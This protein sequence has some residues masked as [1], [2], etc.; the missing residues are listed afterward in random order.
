[1]ALP[2]SAYLQ[3]KESAPEVATIEV[4]SA[5]TQSSVSETA[6]TKVQ[7]R[8][9][10]IG[11]DARARVLKVERTATDL[12]PDAMIRLRYVHRPLVQQSMQDGKW[13]DVRMAG[14]SPIPLLEKGDRVTA[15][16][17][18]LS[19]DEFE[20]AAEAESFAVLAAP[21]TKTD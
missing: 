13:S 10:E 11:V 1:M 5:E 8:R 16:L 18:R 14:A 6:G 4:V 20:P 3:W 7:L 15:W 9:T 17:R 12:Q 2:P 21:L 19:G